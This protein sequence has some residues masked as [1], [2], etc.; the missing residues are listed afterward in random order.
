MCNYCSAR[1]AFS[2]NETPPLLSAVTFFTLGVDAKDLLGCLSECF[3]GGRGPGRPA[4]LTGPPDFD[5]W[6]WRA[7]APTSGPRC[8][9]LLS[10][11][12]AVTTHFSFSLSKVARRIEHEK[13]RGTQQRTQLHKSRFRSTP[14]T[15]AQSLRQDGPPRRALVD[16]KRIRARSGSGSGPPPVLL[17]CVLHVGPAGWP[18][19]VVTPHAASL[20]IANR[21]SSSVQCP[22]GIPSP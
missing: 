22:A 3:R 6:P 16:N 17:I 7:R 20:L 14:K 18:R 9:Q 10:P 21:T 8:F 11:S 1:V 5:G 4:T 13:R 19:C 12:T 15:R 2:P